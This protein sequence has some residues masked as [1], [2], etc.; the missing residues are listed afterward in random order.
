MSDCFDDAGVV[1]NVLGEDQTCECEAMFGANADNTACVPSV[2]APCP[3]GN[4]CTLANQRCVVLADDTTAVGA[5]EV[6]GGQECGCVAE[7]ELDDGVCVPSLGAACTNDVGCPIADQACNV[8]AATQT[9]VCVSTVGGEC[10]EDVDCPLTRQFCDQTPAQPVCA[11]EG[12]WLPDADDGM[13]CNEP[14]FDFCTNLPDG[15]DLNEGDCDEDND[16]RDTFICGVNNCGADRDLAD[17][18]VDPSDPTGLGADTPCDGSA[19]NIWGCCTPDNQCGEN[20][21]DCDTNDDCQAGLV[22]TPDGGA[23]G[24]GDGFGNVFPAGQVDCCKPPTPDGGFYSNFVDGMD[25]RIER[26]TNDEEPVMPRP[27]Y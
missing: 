6:A 9:G 15:C 22:C 23:D 16:C 27:K 10:D 18:C 5:E 20:E 24:C 26:W 14:D 3:L 4:E 17:C 1:S 2:G 21:G 25:I 7:F 8:D 13:R 11:C 19:P 12:G